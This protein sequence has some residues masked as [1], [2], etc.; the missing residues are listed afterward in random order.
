MDD[1]RLLTHSADTTCILVPSLI[2]LVI[3]PEDTVWKAFEF[4]CHWFH[5][6]ALATFAVFHAACAQ[7]IQSSV[8]IMNA[9]KSAEITIVLELKLETIPHVGLVTSIAQ[10]RAAAP[11]DLTMAFHLAQ[12]TC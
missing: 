3:H 11:G 8:M 12:S 1:P 2:I 7:E 9:D 6:P 10:P 5:E 4:A